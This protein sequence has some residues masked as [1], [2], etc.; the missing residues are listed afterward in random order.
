M[1]IL[2]ASPLKKSTQPGDAMAASFRKASGSQTWHFCRNCSDWP[3]DDERYE[4]KMLPAHSDQLCNE[5]RALM[6]EHNCE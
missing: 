6:R 3:K 2:F 1:G 5:C 4:E